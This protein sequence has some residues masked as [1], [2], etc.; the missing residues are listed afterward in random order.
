[1]QE[2]SLFIEA[3]DKED[4]AER[5]AF[6]DH[7]CAGDPALRDRIERLLQRHQQPGSFLGSPLPLPRDTAEEPLREGPGTV[8]GPYKLREQIGAG[9]FLY[10][11]P[12]PV[13]DARPLRVE[14]QPGKFI[15]PRE[16]Q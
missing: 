5:A 13:G 12:D 3:L 2:Q 4:A 16:V 7:A 11:P 9:G 1:M 14:V 10:L 6:L 8:I 15:P